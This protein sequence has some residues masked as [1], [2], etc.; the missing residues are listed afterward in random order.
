MN[1]SDLIS[2]RTGMVE[3]YGR[4]ATNVHTTTLEE[5]QLITSNCITN[6]LAY[7]LVLL[8]RARSITSKEELSD[9]HMGNL[10]GLSSRA[11][12]R[13][14]LSLE[15]AKMLKTLKKGDLHVVLA[16]YEAVVIHDLTGCDVIKL[17]TIRKLCKDLGVTSLT[18]VNLHQIEMHFLANPDMYM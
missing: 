7:Y 18:K 12:Q 3:V 8:N 14:R 2:V 4:K 9:T 15:S 16:G 17:D 10:L 11:I 13:I 6:S 5:I 1:K